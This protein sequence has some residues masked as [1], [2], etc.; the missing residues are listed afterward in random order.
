MTGQSKHFSEKGNYKMEFSFVGDCIHLS[1][2][3]LA[4]PA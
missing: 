2:Q 4:S 1:F 3:M